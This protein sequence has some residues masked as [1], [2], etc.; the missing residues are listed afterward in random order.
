MR[1]ET[2][3]ALELFIEKAG[4]LQSLS[5]T[6]SAEQAGFTWSLKQGETESFE[7]T[8]PDSEQIDAFVL[9][10]RFFVQNNEH[11]SFRWLANNVLDDPGLSNHWK[12]E[13]RRTRRR[14]NDYLDQCPP[15]RVVVG[16]APPPTRREIMETFVYGDLSHTNPSKRATLKEWIIRPSTLGLLKFE[17]IDTLR[18]VLDAIAYIAQ[19]SKLELEK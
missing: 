7:T 2:R 12:Q 6:E 14:I 10:F 8:G 16:G 18:T 3:E 13:F 11:S 9:T 1:T 15:I 4:R 5:F 19:L 17:F